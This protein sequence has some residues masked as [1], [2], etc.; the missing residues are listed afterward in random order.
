MNTLKI[1]TIQ[2]EVVWNILKSQGYFFCDPQKSDFLIEDCGFRDAYKWLIKEME[3]R[4]GPRPKGIKTPIWGWYLRDWKNKKPDLRESGYGKRGTPL[5]C[6]A[7]ELPVNQVVL[8]DFN[9]WH[10][11]LN[12]WYIDDSQTEEEWKKIIENYEKLPYEK[13]NKLMKESWQ[14]IFDI[15]PYK[16]DWRSNG[17]YVQATFWKLNMSQVKDAQYFICK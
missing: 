16:T 15:R 11:V 1:W 17:A 10:S 2:P 8:T 7:L 13:Q 14:T 9:A 4:I 3:K 5:V 6:I 12:R